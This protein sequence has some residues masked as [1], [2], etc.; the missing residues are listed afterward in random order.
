[1][2]T[3]GEATPLLRNRETIDTQ[4]FEKEG[5]QDSAI[6]DS[7][8]YGNG[9]KISWPPFVCLCVFAA[10]TGLMTNSAVAEFPVFAQVLPEKETS[11]A[12]AVVLLQVGIFYIIIILKSCTPCK[13]KQ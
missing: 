10:S 5:E 7:G 6:T 8:E 1:M 2:S 13:G 11:S 3:S 4:Q 9:K 12:Y